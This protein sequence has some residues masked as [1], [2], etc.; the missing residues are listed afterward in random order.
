MASLPIGRSLEPFDPQT[1]GFEAYAERLEQYLL[2]NDISDKKKQVL[3]DLLAPDTPASRTLEELL[4]VLKRQLVIAERFNFHRRHQQLRRLAKTCHFGQFLNDALRDQLVCGLIATNI[5]KRLLSEANLT[6]ERALEIS[7]AMETVEKGAKDFKEEHQASKWQETETAAINV[8]RK[9][10]PNRARPSG[11]EEGCTR[12]AGN[13]HNSWNCPYRGTQCHKCKRVGHLTRACRSS[14]S[15]KETTH[16]VTEP[17]EQE[18]RLDYIG[19][20]K[21]INTKR[22]WIEVELNGIPLKME[23]DTGASVSLV[24]KKTW[25]EK[26]GSPPLTKRKI[27]LR[28]SSGHRLHVIGETTVD[29]NAGSQRHKSL[30]LV[31]VEGEEAPLVKVHRPAPENPPAL[32]EL[33]KRYD[34]IFKQQLGKIKDLKATIRVQSEATPKFFKPRPVAYALRERVEQELER[35]VAIG[36]IEPISHS[37]WAAPIVPVIKNNGDVSM[38]GDFKVTV[39]QCLDIE[40]YPLPKIDDL[41]LPGYGTPRG[42]VPCNVGKEQGSRDFKERNLHKPKEDRIQ[43]APIPLNVTELRSFLGIVNYYGKVIQSVADLC[44]P[45]NELLQKNTPWMWTAT[46][47]ESFNQLKQALGSAEDGSE[48]PIS[49]ASRTLSK[50][51]RNYS[52]IEKEALSIIF[53]LKKFHQYLYGR[54]FLL[55]TD[56]QPLV[57]IFGPKTGISSVV[58][59]RLQRWALCL[60]GYQYDIVY[61]PTQKHGNAD[62]LSRYPSTE[63]EAIDGEEGGDRILALYGPQLAACPLTVKDIERGTMSDALLRQVL[64]FT[65]DGWN[66]T[67]RVDDQLRPYFNRREELSTEGNCLMWGIKAVIPPG[68]RQHIL[69]ELHQGS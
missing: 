1:E 50:A 13:G 39:N 14:G 17:Q 10:V 8:V 34:V 22:V 37:E 5:Q 67:G 18:Y 51:E 3:R 46:C 28:A 49:Y 2:V 59:G 66:K 62:G 47:M 32:D 29:V 25:R 16:Q 27:V 57:K 56:H 19:V 48:R 7:Q 40:Q 36:V 64:K 23:L 6:A 9:P 53:G 15:K 30:P 52:Q 38:C 41:E 24:S 4:E 45:L 69:N 31:V 12:C 61:K 33:L 42:T 21:G 20:L 54:K 11:R 35:L 43:K 26:L 55:V 63:S 44:A 58:A 60:A 65:K 68:M